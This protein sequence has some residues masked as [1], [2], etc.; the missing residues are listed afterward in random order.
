MRNDNVL[1]LVYLTVIRHGGGGNNIKINQTGG[2]GMLWLDLNWVILPPDGINLES[3][4]IIFHYI[5]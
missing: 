5:N 4:K 1:G 3:F 2:S